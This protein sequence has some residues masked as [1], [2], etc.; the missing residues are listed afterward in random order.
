MILTPKYTLTVLIPK[1]D[2]PETI[3]QFRP[4]SLCNVVYKII[5]QVL[6]NRLKQCIHKLVNPLQAGF[7]PGR[8]A[9]DNIIIAQ[10]M[11]QSIRTCRVKK[12]DMM[13]KLDLEKAYDRVNWEFLIETLELL[14]FLKAIRWNVERTE[15]FKP[16]RS[17]RQGDPLSPFLFV[18]YLKHFSMLISL[19]MQTKYMVQFCCLPW[20]TKHP[21]TIIC[22][23]FTSFWESNSK[24]G[25]RCSRCC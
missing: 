17:L 19:I 25:N 24:V 15:T 4:I 14:Q 11:I 3:K 5:A 7:I 9:A 8:Q 22:P 10:E 13:V 16:S 21:A 1:T 18:I 20:W 12:G 2:H 6:V 23:R